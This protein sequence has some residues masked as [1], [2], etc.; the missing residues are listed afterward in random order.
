MKK[1]I[2][3]ALVILGVAGVAGMIRKRKNTR[4]NCY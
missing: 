2:I 4:Y 1:L 3:S